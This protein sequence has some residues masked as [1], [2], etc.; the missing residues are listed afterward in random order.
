[1]KRS[2]VRKGVLVCGLLVA[3]EASALSAPW[4]STRV[5]DRAAYA[6]RLHGMWLGECIANWTGLRTEGRAI[7]PPFYTDADWGTTPPGYPFWLSI[8]YVLSGAGNATTG[9]WGADDDTDIEYVYVHLLNQHQTPILTPAQISQGWIRHINRSI[10]VSNAAARET[11]DRGLTP[12]MTA[13]AQGVM[14][15]VS[16]GGDR[17][18]M[19]DAQL[20]TEVF[21]ALWPGMPGQALDAADLPIRATSHGFATHASQFFVVLYSLATQ[22]PAGLSGRDQTLWL[23]REARKYIPDTSKSADIADFVLADYLSNP[24]ASDWERTRDRV[25]DRYEL[26]AAAN[27]FVFRAWYESSVNFATGLIALLYSEGDIKKAIRVGTLS[28]W[29]SD[30][31]TA[32]MGG[33]FGLMLGRQGVVSA[34]NNTVSEDRFWVERTRDNLPDYVPGEAGVE[35]TLAGLSARMLAIVDRS[36]ASAGGIVGATSWLLPPGGAGPGVLPSTALLRSPTH[37]LWLRSANN[38]I[39][40]AGGT[41]T[42]TVIPEPNSADGPSALIANGYELDFSGAEDFGVNGPGGGRRQVKTF[43]PTSLTGNIQTLMV[44]YDRPVTVHTIRYFEADAYLA[45]SVQGGWFDAL[46]PEVR[47][48]GVWIPASAVQSEPLVREIPFQMIDFVLTSPVLATGIRVSGP[49]GGTPGGRG[50]LSAMELDALTPP[51]QL[52]SGFDRSADGRLT[53]DDLYAQTAL[54]ADLDNDGVA[55]FQDSGYLEAAL[56]WDESRRMAP[57]R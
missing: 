25:Y 13:L 31:G 47:V 15:G 7:A 55:G 45:G 23:F 12:P 24:D 54:P 46:T 10:W 33:L 22:I 40:R 43:L 19:I 18:Q 29:D 50:Y 1:M 20:T 37:R 51:L 41:V 3:S 16:Q 44:E 30:N 49:I 35:D 48:N 17:S 38:Q 36:V 32:T 27:G 6:E 11:M 57:G 53:I 52:E 34:F 21:G 56:R 9:P 14:A 28:G 39:R 26:N 8:T 2:V 5:I 4:E 42:G